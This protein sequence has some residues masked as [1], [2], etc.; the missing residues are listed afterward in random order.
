[1]NGFSV[2]SVNKEICK[3]VIVIVLYYTQF[4]ECVTK[5]YCNGLYVMFLEAIV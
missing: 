4:N 1:M 5:C 2:L 3:T